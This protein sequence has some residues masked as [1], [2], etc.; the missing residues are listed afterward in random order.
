MANELAYYIRLSLAD[1]ETGKVKDESESISNQRAL[2]LKYI[3]DHPEFDGWKVHEFVDDGYSGTN[4]DRPD[5]QRMIERV[6]EGSIQC[7]IVK[8]LSR[9]ARNYILLGEY[10]EQI[11][12]YLGVRF[13]AI[14][15]GYDSKT[16][17][18]AADNMSIVL[19]SVLNAYYSKELSHKIRATYN[20]KMQKNQYRGMPPFG[21]Q[22]NQDHTQYVLD[23]DAARIVRLMFDL[24][25]EGK[26]GNQISDYLNSH[27]I[28]TIS[29]YNHSRAKAFKSG[30][31]VPELPYWDSTKVVPLLRNPVY[32]GTVV[33][34]KATVVSPASK[35]KRRTELSEQYIFDNCHDPIVSAEEFDRVQAFFPRQKRKAPHNKLEYPLK[36]IVFC[37]TCKRTMQRYRVRKSPD[38]YARY[39]CRTIGQEHSACS[40]KKYPEKELEQ[41]VLQSLLPMLKTIH[42]SIGRRRSRQEQSQSMLSS[43]QQE[44]RQASALEKKIRLEKLEIYEAY[45]EGTLPIQG[46]RKQKAA[47]TRQGKEIAQ[48][49]AALRDQEAALQSGILPKELTQLCDMAKEYQSSQILT[50]EMVA[51]FVERVYA[52]E[53]HY[54]I[55]WKFQ[56]IWEQ[57]GQINA[58]GLLAEMEA[59]TDE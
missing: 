6:H 37:G 16:S 47:L 23:P 39:V 12:P 18:S 46:Y 4:G 24:A 56:D 49:L 29:E 15:D 7:I 31:P 26:N 19:K 55:V 41:I 35:K 34:N 14:N 21:Y 9:F 58:D 45:I 50:K 43:C 5:F 27:D 3:S 17:T 53:D 28:P 1:E 25:L 10:V 22:Y 59:N 52:F 13:I 33:L 38:E 20:L 44:L 51:A 30:V 40:K 11:F 36:G 42:E 57:L 48:K 54:E 32:K 2:I 8:D